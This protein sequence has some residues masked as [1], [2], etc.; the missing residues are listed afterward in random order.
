MPPGFVRKTKKRNTNNTT[1]FSF[2]YDAM[3]YDIVDT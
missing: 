3:G 2:T 1:V